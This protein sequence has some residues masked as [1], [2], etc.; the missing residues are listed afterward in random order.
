MLG[1][2]SV[3][4]IIK[5]SSGKKSCCLSLKI[6]SVSI[7]SAQLSPSIIFILVNPNNLEIVVLSEEIGNI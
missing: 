1:N 5:S 3:S 6:S 2:S 7:K 4:D